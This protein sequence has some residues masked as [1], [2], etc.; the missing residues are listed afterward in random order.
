MTHYSPLTVLPDVAENYD[1]VTYTVEPATNGTALTIRQ[2]R[3]RSKNEVVESEK[4]WQMVLHN[5]EQYLAHDNGI[6]G[7]CDQ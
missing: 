6:D 1:T 3:N 4:L 5:L 2:S 7:S